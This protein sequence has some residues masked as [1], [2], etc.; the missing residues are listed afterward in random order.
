ME[1]G[2][3]SCAER[4]SCPATVLVDCSCAPPAQAAAAQPLARHPC[5]DTCKQRGTA[6]SMARE[7]VSAGCVSTTSWCVMNWITHVLR[8]LF[9][10]KHQMAFFISR[11]IGAARRGPWS[12]QC[13]SRASLHSQVVHVTRGGSPWT[14]RDRSPVQKVFEDVV[15]K[16]HVQICQRRG[17]TQQRYL[18]SSS[19]FSA[20]CKIFRTSKSRRLQ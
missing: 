8:Q 6:R 7:Q 11:R 19:K 5:S 12:N 4:C 16:R 15:L 3:R 2:G 14:P 10:Q 18:A 13:T 17:G 1:R 9:S 20:L